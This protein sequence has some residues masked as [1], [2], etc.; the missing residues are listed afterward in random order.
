M[1]DKKEEEQK[2]YNIF[3]PEQTANLAKLY[4]LQE[5]IVDTMFEGGRVPTSPREVEVANTTINSLRDSIFQQTKLELKKEDNENQADLAAM[6][7]ELLDKVDEIK[8]ENGVYIPKATSQD[9]SEF[10]N[11]I[12]SIDIEVVPGELEIRPEPLNPSDFVGD[13]EDV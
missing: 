5:K 10:E 6:A 4:N 9:L 13:K 2:S 12:D 11:N 8:S 1:P 3:T 7:A